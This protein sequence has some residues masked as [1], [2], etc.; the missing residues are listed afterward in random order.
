[1]SFCLQIARKKRESKKET[2]AKAQDA[3][4][5]SFDLFLR[6]FASLRLCVKMPEI[7]CRI[8]AFGGDILSKA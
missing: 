5:Q 7:I 3:E 2:N 8:P 6:A 1:V 4:T